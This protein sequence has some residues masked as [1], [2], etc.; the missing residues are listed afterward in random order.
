MTKK[1]AFL[2]LAI[3]MP[4]LFLSCQSYTAAK[5]IASIEPAPSTFTL[6]NARVLELERSLET[7]TALLASANRENKRLQDALAQIEREAAREKDGLQKEYT[8]SQ[9]QPLTYPQL[10][11]SK[12]STSLAAEGEALQAVMLPLDDCPWDNEKKSYEVQTLID[13]LDIPLIFVTGHQENVVALLDAIQCNAVLLGTGAIITSFPILQMSTYGVEI[14]YQE[15]KTLHLIVA[16]LPEYQ[17][18]EHFMRGEPWQATQKSIASERLTLLQEML[19]NEESSTPTLLGASL[20]EPSYQDWK[21]SSPVAYRQGGYHWPL[22]EYLEQEGFYDLYA[23]THPLETPGSGSTYT[24]GEWE[25]RVDFLYSRNILPLSSTML[26]IPSLE[27]GGTR[28][29]VLGTFLLP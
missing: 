26:R 21:P 12:Y 4:L 15:G 14:Q 9:S 11:T 20:Y 10:Y 18:V 16:N 7:V 19:A 27:G 24:T 23:L 25:E 13:K 2:L 17:V 29:A 5:G 28:S 1:R 8:W 22:S 3:L 6:L